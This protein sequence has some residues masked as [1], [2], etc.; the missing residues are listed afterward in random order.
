MKNL[1]LKFMT[2]K[3]AGRFEL[4]EKDSFFLGE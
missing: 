1:G 2:A 3:P 4:H